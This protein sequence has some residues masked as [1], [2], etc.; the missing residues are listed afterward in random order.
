M[1]LSAAV[2]FFPL[3]FY[4]CCDGAMQ[5]SDRVTLSLS[6]FFSTQHHGHTY[7]T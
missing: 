6:I 5:C 3:S 1:S 4:F 7:I 2:P